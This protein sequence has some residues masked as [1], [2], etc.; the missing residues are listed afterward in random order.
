MSCKKIVCQLC[1]VSLLISFLPLISWA[2]KEKVGTTSASLLKIGAGARA[3]AM[4]D[5]S[6]A[7][8]DNST[9]V[10]W[11]PA[12]L[13]FLEKKEL[14]YTH[15]LWFQ[16]ITHGFL[17][18]AHPLNGF[19]LGVGIDYL[20]MGEVEET[21]K[22][23][24]EGTGRKISVED[25]IIA[26]FS[27]SK[28]M[29]EDLSL[30]VNIKYIQYKAADE[31][32]AG[33]AADLGLRYK[34]PH[35]NLGLA[36]QNRG[37]RMRFVEK[38]FALPFNVKAGLAYKGIQNTTLALDV[39]LPSDNKS[40]Y[41][42][43]GEYRINNL[44]AIRAGYNSR[45]SD[46]KLGEFN[47]GEGLS[48]G[49]GVNFKGVQLDIAYVSYGDLGDIYRV[50]FLTGFDR[51]HREEEEREEKGGQTEIL[52]PKVADEGDY[53]RD[54][55]NLHVSWCEEPKYQYA[56]G[57]SPGQTDVVGWR[58]VCA[59]PE[60]DVAGG[61]YVYA[62]PE[63]T[64]TGLNLKDGTTYYFS[65]KA[66]KK[67]FFL[68]DTWVN[69]GSSNGITVDSTPPEK[70]VV[71]DDGIYTTSN[72]ALQFSW[73]SNDE[74]SGIKE[75]FYA[76]GTTPNGVDI[77]GWKSA[78]TKRELT[79]AGLDLSNGETYYLSVKV[80]DHAGNESTIGSSDGITME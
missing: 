52:A 7:V 44:W 14:S 42:L 41:H 77:S 72:K 29:R 3:A 18:Y 11:N 50:S 19:W 15:S 31:T 23:K 57:T 48:A 33:Y 46:N 73:I 10:Y 45:I 49:F 13:G 75:Y 58:F 30:G 56:I 79:L 6:C 74:V 28:R 20:S 62:K 1:L 16:D 21:T 70:P 12:G 38:E 47:L 26:I 64:V 54:K 9:A 27:L 8:S 35:L 32:A 51:R 66:R 4:G 25:D 17:S 22:L 59:K 53:T 55:T 60:T 76:L 69:L 34:L 36:L 61:R 43:G 5:A 40:S 24:P 39:N 37:T 63:A 67:K 68:F 78:G 65:V 2:R 71:T 80:L